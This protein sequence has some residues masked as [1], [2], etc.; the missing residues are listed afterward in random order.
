ADL[1]REPQFTTFLSLIET[2][3]ITYDWRGFTTP[4]GKY[5]GKN[6]GNAWR[7]KKK[8]RNLLFGSVEKIELL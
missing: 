6:H 2:G 4:S 7:I 3:G 5:Q 8:Y 1:S